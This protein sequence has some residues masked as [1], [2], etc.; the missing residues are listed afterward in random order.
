MCQ[1]MK[2]KKLKQG[3]IKRLMWKQGY[4]SLSLFYQYSLEDIEQNK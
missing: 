4:F 3:Y 1:N 2:K